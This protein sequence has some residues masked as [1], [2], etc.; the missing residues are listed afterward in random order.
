[1]GTIAEWGRIRKEIKKEFEEK[2]ITYCEVR[3]PD[4][5]MN[6]NFL[7]FAHRHKRIWYDMRENKGKLG[8]FNQVILACTPCHDRLEVDKELA[9]RLFIGLRG[10]EN[11]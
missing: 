8:N 4:V 1:M 9:E 6:D 11:I 10:E 3:F 7:S 5:C 2:G